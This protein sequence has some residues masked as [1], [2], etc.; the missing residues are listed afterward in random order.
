MYSRLHQE[1]LEHQSAIDSFQNQVKNTTQELR[2]RDSQ[3]EN[4]KKLTHKFSESNERLIHE[5]EILNSQIASLESLKHAKEQQILKMAEELKILQSKNAIQEKSL[6]EFQTN[7]QR[8]LQ[9]ILEMEKV[10]EQHSKEKAEVAKHVE[11]LTGEVAELKEKME[12]GLHMELLLD[13]EE[14]INDCEM[15]NQGF[16]DNQQLIEKLFVLCEN[17]DDEVASS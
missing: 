17:A 9:Q 7:M 6:F 16:I 11:E 1:R 2:L 8:K 12:D 10:I 4:Q 13:M 5:N 15:Y 3:F 14:W